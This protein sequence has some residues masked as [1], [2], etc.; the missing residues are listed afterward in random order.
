MA[1]NLKPIEPREFLSNVPSDKRR[2]K[3]S[4]RIAKKLWGRSAEFIAGYLYALENQDD[5]VWYYEVDGGILCTAD[6]IRDASV[7]LAAR[8]TAKGSKP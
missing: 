6:D 8:R 4:K 1:R 7:E 2:I 3:A 5:Y